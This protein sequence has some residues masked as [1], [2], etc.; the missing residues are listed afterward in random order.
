M[1]IWQARTLLREKESEVKRGEQR[2]RELEGHLAEMKV[3]LRLLA[4][5]IV[6]LLLRNKTEVLQTFSG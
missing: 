3:L 6:R 1:T 2:Q 5:A 4:L